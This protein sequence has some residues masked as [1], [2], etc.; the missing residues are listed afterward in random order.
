MSLQARED[1][2]K[3]NLKFSLYPRKDGMFTCWHFSA[4]HQGGEWQDELES[5]SIE[6]DFCCEHST[7][8]TLSRHKWRCFNEKRIQNWKTAQELL[9]QYTALSDDI[10]LEVFFPT[11]SQ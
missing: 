5:E 1:I 10:L 3:A 2:L 7:F 11:Q 8:N 4:K 6:R 9:Q